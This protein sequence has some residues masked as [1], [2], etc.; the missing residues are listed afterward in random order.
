MIFLGGPLSHRGQCRHVPPHA[1]ILV[2]GGLGWSPRAPRSLQPMLVLVW[3]DVEEK[4]GWGAIGELGPLKAAS[5][6]EA[7]LSLPL[8]AH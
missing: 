4:R 5:L 6:G 3:V 2:R 1:L 7:S 8:P